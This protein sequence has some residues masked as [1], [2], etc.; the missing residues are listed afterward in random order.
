MFL[1]VPQSLVNYLRLNVDVF[2]KAASWTFVLLKVNGAL[3][4]F[5]ILREKLWHNK[6]GSSCD[7]IKETSQWR[8]KRRRDCKVIYTHKPRINL[9]SYP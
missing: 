4:G 6:R 5:F 9:A 3:S 2:W 8:R 7:I 1:G